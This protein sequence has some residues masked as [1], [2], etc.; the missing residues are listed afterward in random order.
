M[1]FTA[2]GCMGEWG[3]T[4]GR[5]CGRPRD[6]FEEPNLLIRAPEDREGCSTSLIRNGCGF[7]T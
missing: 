7:Q 5:P 4:K 1:I 3:N 6:W 2:R